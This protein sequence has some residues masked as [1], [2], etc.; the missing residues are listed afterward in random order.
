MINHNMTP[1]AQANE[2][3]LAEHS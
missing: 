1:R 3:G 2:D